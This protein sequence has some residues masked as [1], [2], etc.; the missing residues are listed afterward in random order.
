MSPESFQALFSDSNH[1]IIIM[2]AKQQILEK[3][4]SRTSHGH[5]SNCSRSSGTSTTEEML[6]DP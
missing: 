4:T 5:N 1:R 2:K 6:S 3:M